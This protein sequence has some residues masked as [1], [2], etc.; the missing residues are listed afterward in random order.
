MLCEKVT[1]FH[2]I[3]NNFTNCAPLVMNNIRTTY[4]S[5]DVKYASRPAKIKL[6]SFL[7]TSYGLDW[8][9]SVTFAPVSESIDV[10][11]VF[12]VFYSGHVFFTFST[13]FSTFFI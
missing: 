3:V 6:I 13:F 7:F 12:Y 2:Y 9:A 5:Y 10:I 11:N 4:I 8:K 1:I